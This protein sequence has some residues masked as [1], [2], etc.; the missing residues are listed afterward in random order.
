MDICS[1]RPHFLASKSESNSNCPP[2]RLIKMPSFM[3]VFFAQVQISFLSQVSGSV[4]KTLAGRSKFAPPF[5]ASE[6]NPT[7]QQAARCTGKT[8]DTTNQEV[9]NLTSG[10]Y[11][12]SIAFQP[13]T[14][15]VHDGVPGTLLVMV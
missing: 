6:W 5:M 7:Q 2:S 3:G 10:W 14:R 1:A 15:F 9:S 12:E 8:L 11:S 4:Y 13:K